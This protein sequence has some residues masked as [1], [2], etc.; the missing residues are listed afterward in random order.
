MRPGPEQ[1]RLSDYTEKC[2]KEYLKREN[3]AEELLQTGDVQGLDM[4][5]ERGDW[6]SALEGAKSNGPDVLNRYL[7]RYA[8]ETMESGKFGDTVTAFA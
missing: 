7:M 6:H 3:K 8:K 1:K 4:F 5:V 2:Y